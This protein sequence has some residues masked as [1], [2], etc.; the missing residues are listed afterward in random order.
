[1]KTIT[2]FAFVL[3]A[4][5]LSSAC[6][7]HSHEEKMR[8]QLI[9]Q[10]RQSQLA[11]LAE[12]AQQEQALRVQQRQQQAHA[13]AHWHMLHRD[14][15]AMHIPFKQQI[16]TLS[17]SKTYFYTF[18]LFA[19]RYQYA[20]QQ[21]PFT[22]VGLRTVTNNAD[23]IALLPDESA[24]FL[25]T[26]RI[27][28]VLE[29]VLQQEMTR[30][31]LQQTVIKP[32]GQRWVAVTENIK[33]QPT[34]QSIHHEWHWDKGAFTDLI[35][36]T[37]PENAHQRIQDRQLQAHMG[38]RFCTTNRCRLDTSYQDH[39]THAI[40]AEVMSVLIVHPPSGD[41]LAEFYRTES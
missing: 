27:P 3:C 17:A 30:N 7:Q 10:Q 38:F 15:S 32:Q 35:W 20:Q 40:R 33:Q 19:E 23:Y 41:I 2:P 31:R 4:T 14:N 25:G 36:Q 18:D 37:S 9:E 39:P 26:A 6:S 29:F 12:Q 13:H 16:D 11:L 8:L 5:L 24:R 1:M 21:Q 28:S 22:L 34:L